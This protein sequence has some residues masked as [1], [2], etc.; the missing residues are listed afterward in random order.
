[1]LSNGERKAVKEDIALCV[2][3]NRNEKVNQLYL[4]RTESIKPF[5][6]TDD[7]MG[8]KAYYRVIREKESSQ[9]SHTNET[10]DF[11]TFITDEV[12][13]VQK[14]TETGYHFVL[15]LN[16]RE[17]GIVASIEE[18]VLQPVNVSLTPQEE[19]KEPVAAKTVSSKNKAVF[20]RRAKKRIFLGGH[21]FQDN[22]VFEPIRILLED[23]KKKV[24]LFSPAALDFIGPGD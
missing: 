4:V 1:M 18:E 10:E 12:S 6:F 13:V 9:D 7:E 15:V 22:V 11:V 23:A 5:D 14:K 8:A 2:Q 3:L 21:V 19:G 17:I 20:Y 16:E 24:A